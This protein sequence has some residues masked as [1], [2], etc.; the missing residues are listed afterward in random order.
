MNEAKAREIHESDDIMQ[1]SIEELCAADDWFKEYALAKLA[2]RLSA[3]ESKVVRDYMQL[4]ARHHFGSVE[5]DD[6]LKA[7]DCHPEWLK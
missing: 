4:M 3:I 5:T 2:V 7:M 1:Y 6:M